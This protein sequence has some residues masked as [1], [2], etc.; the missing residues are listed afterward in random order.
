MHYDTYVKSESQARFLLVVLLC[1]L[2][3]TGFSNTISVAEVSIGRMVTPK[4]TYRRQGKHR[5]RRYRR[6]CALR[7]RGDALVSSGS[8]YCR[9][10]W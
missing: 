10:P 7:Q 9:A 8:R 2:S 4:F 1:C 3:S 6:S 5:Y